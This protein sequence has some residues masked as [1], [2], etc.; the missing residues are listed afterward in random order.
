MS[1][2]QMKKVLVALGIALACLSASAYD[3][4]SPTGTKGLILIDKQGKLV[5]FFD[6]SFKEL[7]SLSIEGT[8]HELAISPDRKFAYVPD[9]GDGVYGRNPNPGHSIA[10]ID[11]A[12]AKVT[13]TIDIAPY[14]A[15]HG[16]QVDAKG[17]LYAACDLSRKLLVIDPKAKKIVDA[18][19]TDGTGHW[20]ALTPDGSKAYVANKND[21]LF[22]S[23]ID[24]KAKKLI[25]RVPMPKGTQ[26]I[27]ASPD[28]KHILAMDLA[29]ARIAVIDTKTDKV[30]DEIKMEGS[31]KGAWGARYSPDGKSLV[32][33]SV[34][35]RSATILPASDLHAAQATMKVGAA[36]FGV[37][38][39][40]DSKTALVPNH[41]DGTVSVIDLTKKEVVSSFKGGVG[42]E[43]LSYY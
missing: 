37:A 7:S 8:P 10:I 27:V 36:P 30:V 5:R 20:V 13:G 32:I 43:T 17:M 33:V 24:I 22:V 26:G 9:Y 6:T 16:L 2:M 35:D 34:N 41:G 31:T 21:R 12:S 14:Q 42:I 39:S 11:L 1:E 40:A 23:V 19:D 15:P 38:F 28:G 3:L 29:E 4:N 25:E 18:I